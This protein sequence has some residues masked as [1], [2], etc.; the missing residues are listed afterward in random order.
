MVC[1]EMEKG[2]E[3]K[4]D[5]LDQNYGLR[6]KGFTLVVEELKQRITGKVTKVQRYGNRIKQF[7]YSR[8]FESNPGRFLKNL[9]GKEE[10]TKPLNPEDAT[11]FWKRIWSIKVKHKRNTEWIAKAKMKMPSEKQ[12]SENH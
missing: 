11:A 6:R 2:Q 1:R 3:K 9:E 4:K 7:Q 8:N 12:C 5:R 10:R